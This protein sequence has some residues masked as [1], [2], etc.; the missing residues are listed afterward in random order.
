ENINILYVEINNYTITLNNLTTENSVNSVLNKQANDFFEYA[1]KKLYSQA[2]EAYK[3]SI[4]NDF[5]FHTYEAYLNYTL[6]YNQNCYLSDYYD[7]YQY[8]GG[9][10]GNTVRKSNTW[11]LQT[12]QL[13]PLFWFFQSVNYE[14]MIIDYIIKLADKN[15]AENPGIYFDNYA[16]LIRETFDRNN[17]YLSKDG[18]VIYFNQYEIAPYSSGIIEF[19]VPYEMLS[20]E[21]TCNQ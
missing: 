19:V 4:Q 15:I 11:N 16:E 12:G 1:S 2:L 6:T 18:I 7:N 13:V 20:N 14:N 8:T 3:D 10:H 17:F 21:P 5:P 9:A